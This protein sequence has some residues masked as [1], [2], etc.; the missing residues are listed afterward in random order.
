M[1]AS[2]VAHDAEESFLHKGERAVYIIKRASWVILNYA[3]YAYI[4]TT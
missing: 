4:E 3:A 2:I 1:N